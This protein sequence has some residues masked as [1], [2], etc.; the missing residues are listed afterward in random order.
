MLNLFAFDG[1]F[2]FETVA[3]EVATVTLGIE[4]CLVGFVTP[5]GVD[6]VGRFTGDVFSPN[7]F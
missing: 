7:V 3:V 6:A 4:A 2:A 1:D 5:L